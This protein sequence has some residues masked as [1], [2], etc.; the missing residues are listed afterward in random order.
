MTRQEFNS[1]YK[2]FC[3]AFPDTAAWLNQSPERTETLGFWYQALEHTDLVDAKE[4]TR[5]LAVGE[6]AEIPAY[7]RQ[8]IPR[9]VAEI[10]K[11][12]R[13]GRRIVKRDEPMLPDYGGAKW[14]LLA[15]F[16]AA[17]QR[18]KTLAESMKIIA[19][20]IPV[21]SNPRRYKC[22]RCLDHGM[23]LVWANET[24][25]AVANNAERIPRKRCSLRCD[26]E[27]SKR[28]SEAIPVYDP[29]RY[30]LFSGY[31]QLH[32]VEQWVETYKACKVQSMPNY[33]P[34]FESWS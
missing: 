5:R 4:A 22:L 14:S 13:S 34:A 21:D 26:C 16:K 30:C 10:A 12:V 18:G 33:E 31:D 29:N 23:V 17:S 28:W 7:E 24:I 19:E 27:A 9:R 8:S 20:M 3:A 25:H 32:E 1:W 6:E 15:A 2:S 11:R